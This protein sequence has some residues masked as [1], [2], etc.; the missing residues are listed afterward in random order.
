[1]SLV[2]DDYQNISENSQKALMKFK[3]KTESENARTLTE[4]L[5]ENLHTLTSSLPLLIRTAG[6][7][8]H[9]R[10]NVRVQ[11]YSCRFSS[12]GHRF[13]HVDL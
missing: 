1:M 8:C 13:D 2:A 4:V 3:N 10:V 5:E 6:I 12:I 7:N 11:S 9:C